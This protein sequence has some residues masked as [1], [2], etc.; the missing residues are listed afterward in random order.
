MEI[1]TKPKQRWSPPVIERIDAQ[2]E[3]ITNNLGPGTDTSTIAFSM[4]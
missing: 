1:A 2:L 4:S 3:D